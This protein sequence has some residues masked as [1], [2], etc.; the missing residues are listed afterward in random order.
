[1]EK[2]NY[3]KPL[4]NSEEFVPQT[5]V[6]ACGYSGGGTI[7]GWRFRTDEMTGTTAGLAKSAED[8]SSSIIES[9]IGVNYLTDLFTESNGDYTGIKSEYSSQ[10][11]WNDSDSDGII[12]PGEYIT[13]YYTYTLN[14]VTNSTN[15]N[16]RINGS[17][18]V[19]NP[20]VDTQTVVPGTTKNLS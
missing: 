8:T 4:L 1:M 19:A 12:E 5:Y 17:S 15:V 2:R 7:N 14:G 16:F 11:V 20:A 3:V 13:Y 18:T 10:F 6:A 9:P